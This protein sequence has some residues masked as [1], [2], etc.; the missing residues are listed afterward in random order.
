MN[1]GRIGRVHTNDRRCCR[2]RWR[3]TD[4]LDR[5]PEK[6]QRED[7]VFWRKERLE[8]YVE[9]ATATKRYVAIL[10]RVAGHRGVDSSAQPIALE[11]ALPLLAE[12][13]HRRDEAFERVLLVS[14]SNSIAD[15]AKA[16]VSKVYV[17]RS[18][19]DRPDLSESEWKAAV[20]E[21]NAHR[22]EFR[23]AVQN[24]IGIG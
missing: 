17:L 10:Y 5:R 11:A 22:A 24:E 6:V 20:E 12:A 15:C 3:C 4:H 2:C 7:V 14:Q 21:A 13:F 16:W 19:L 18:L 23:G 1:H 8:T 9:F